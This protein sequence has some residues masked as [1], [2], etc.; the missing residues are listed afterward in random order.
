MCKNKNIFCLLFNVITSL[1][2]AAGIAGVFFLG[3]IASV[4]ALLFITLILGIIGILAIILSFVCNKREKCECLESGCLIAS[5]VGSVI[6]SIFALTVT[7]LPTFTVG[8][9]ILVGAVAFFLVYQI[10]NLANLLICRFCND[11]C[12]KHW[13]IKK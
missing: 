8:V 13:L 1:I 11:K 3:L 10:I 2:A 12:D 6:T 9:A 4:P 5:T 7:S